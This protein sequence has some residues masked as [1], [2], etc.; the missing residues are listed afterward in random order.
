MVKLTKTKVR[1]ADVSATAKTKKRKVTSKANAKVAADINKRVRGSIEAM[2]SVSIGALAEANMVDYGTYTIMQRAIPMLYDGMKPVHRRSIY[3]MSKMGLFSSVAHRKAAKVVGE[4]MGNYHPHGDASIYGAM[5]GISTGNGGAHPLI[6][7]QG[8]WGNFDG[9]GPFKGAAA[10]RYTECRLT[11]L[12]TEVVTNRRYMDESKKQV[13]PYVPNYDGTMEEPLYLPATLPMLFLLGAEGIATGVTV[14]MPEY[15][16]ES[17]LAAT[18][19]LLRTGKGKSAS[20]KLVPTQ[21]WGAV[22]QATQEELDAY[23]ETGNGKIAWQAPYE[24]VRGKGPTIIRLTGLPPQ[25]YG[26]LSE[27]ILKIKGVGGFLNLASKKGGLLFD[28]IV[29]DE[30]CLS[31]V[32]KKLTV[33]ESYRSATT[34]LV[35]NDDPTVPLKVAFEM[36]T[37]NTILEKWLE[38]RLELEQRVIKATMRDNEEEIRRLNLMVLAASKLDIIV[39]VLKAK[40]GDKVAMLEKKLKVTNAEAKEIW[41]MAVRQL[42]KLNADDTKAKIKALEAANK[43]LKAEY[44]APAERIL[45][46]L[47]ADPAGVK[48]KKAAK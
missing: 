23:H 24:V 17:V 26:S 20:K 4:T 28:I 9:D 48:K 16:Y 2:P 27:G 19:V 36:W 45:K 38:W 11:K 21:R 13:I 32:K 40:A 46:Q 15:T 31:A 30:S 22:C 18:K 25:S 7:G 47:P 34:L 1:V 33:N 41:Q 14:N 35:K 3:A 29:K 39:E 37:P 42:D 10:P 43:V 8:N 5:V 44:K 6:D 12:A